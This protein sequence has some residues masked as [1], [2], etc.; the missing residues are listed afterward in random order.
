[1]R[2]I[3]MIFFSLLFITSPKMSFAWGCTGH[4][5]VALIAKNRLSPSALSQV[6]TLLKT[7]QNPFKI[8]CSPTT[9]G[10]MASYS[11]WADDAR[12]KPAYKDTGNWHFWDVPLGVDTATVDQYCDEGECIVAALK[13]ETDILRDPDSKSQD[14]QVA[15]IFIIHLVGDAHQPL[16]IIDNGDRGGN[17][18]P[19]EFNAEGHDLKPREG[20]KN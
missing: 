5:T 20:K 15:L 11:T 17:C 9:T 19:V 2:A 14:R 1:M 3:R 6:N 7:Y 10:W 16:H 8:T 18:L 12:T 4:E 13:K